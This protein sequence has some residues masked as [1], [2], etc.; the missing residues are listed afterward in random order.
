MY[1]G[2]MDKRVI[3]SILKSFKN[4]STTIAACKAAGIHVSTLWRWCAKWPK[5]EKRI[6]EIKGKR[7]QFVVDSIYTNAIQ[8][9]EGSQKLF[10]E[11]NGLIKRNGPVVNVPVEVTNNTKVNIPVSTPQEAE[12]VKSYAELIR[13]HN[14]IS[15]TL[16]Q[17]GHGLVPGG[18][19]EGRQGVEGQ[20][21]RIAQGD[22]VAH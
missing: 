21:G 12:Q 13:S 2:N 6:E 20:A 15:R 17:E 3:K 9:K 16:G 4:G 10:C 8:G 11:L 18:D 22:S 1:T 14:L 7:V 5:L 19:I